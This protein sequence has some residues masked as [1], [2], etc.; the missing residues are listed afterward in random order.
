M[1][2]LPAALLS[3]LVLSFVATGLVACSKADGNILTAER[4]KK[5]LEKCTDMWSIKSVGPVLKADKGNTLEVSFEYV[6][7]G[8]PEDVW[9][10]NSRFSPDQEGKWYL[11]LTWDSHTSTHQACGGRL[12]M[13]VE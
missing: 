6:L 10:G 5:A 8:T 11:S 7:P 9:K 13:L 12:P 2:A 4:A 3:T 1:K